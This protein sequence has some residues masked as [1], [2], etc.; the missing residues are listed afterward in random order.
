MVAA[1]HYLHIPL[2]T[3]G[4]H[5]WCNCY[6]VMQQQCCVLRIILAFT[7]SLHGL[8]LQLLCMGVLLLGMPVGVVV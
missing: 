8:A 1:K 3:S 7:G 5:V 4:C 2:Q 6:V